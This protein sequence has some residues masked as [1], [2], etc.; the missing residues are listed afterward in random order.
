MTLRLWFVALVGPAAWLAHLLVSYA[1]VPVSCEQGRSVWLY[2]T[3]L[4]T[5]AAAVAATVVAARTLARARAG[6]RD[7]AGRAS[8]LVGRLQRAAG[9]DGASGVPLVLAVGLLFGAF[10]LLV[11][12]MGGIAPTIVGPCE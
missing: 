5:G 10:Y 7:D 3:T 4:V 6:R 1:L 8:D 9:R 11:V 12:V 2:L